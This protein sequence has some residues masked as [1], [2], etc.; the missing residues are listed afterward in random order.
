MYNVQNL[1]NRTGLFPPLRFV[2]TW[3]KI[4]WCANWRKEFVLVN[5]DG[6]R[7]FHSLQVY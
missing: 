4:N 6:R 7:D 2:I 5:V 3:M 1:A